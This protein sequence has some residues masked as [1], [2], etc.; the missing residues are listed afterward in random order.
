[1]SSRVGILPKIWGQGAGRFRSG[2][3]MAKDAMGLSQFQR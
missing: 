2:G 3:L 1:M